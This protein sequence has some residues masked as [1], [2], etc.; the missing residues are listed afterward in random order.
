MPFLIFNL[1][2][3]RGNLPQGFILPEE[4]KRKIILPAIQFISVLYGQCNRCFN[5]AAELPIYLFV[6]F[7]SIK[8]NTADLYLSASGETL[9]GVFPPKIMFIEGWKKTFA[10]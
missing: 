8:D 2:F 6:L 10:S 3:L 5:P 9:L 4:S 1:I 7:I